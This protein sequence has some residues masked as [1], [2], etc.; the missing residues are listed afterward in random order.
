MAPP[1]VLGTKNTTYPVSTHKNK[2]KGKPINC[3]F[4]KPDNVNKMLGTYPEFASNPLPAEIQKSPFY[5]HLLCPSSTRHFRGFPV[6]RDT[7]L[8]ET[9]K[10]LPRVLR[11]Q[12]VCILYPASGSH[13][14]PLDLINHIFEQEDNK[15]NSA[16]II[17]TEIKEAALKELR[18]LLNKL[19]K[20]GV[21]AGLKETQ[22]NYPNGGS[23]TTFAFSY[24]G[25]EITL[26]FALNMSGDDYYKEE[27]LSESDV[28]VIHDPGVGD[29]KSSFKLLKSF[30]VSA[31]NNKIVNPPVI[32]MEN[33]NDYSAPSIMLS[34]IFNPPSKKEDETMY[35]N[36]DLLPGQKIKIPFPYGHRVNYGELPETGAAFYQSAIVYT[37]D[38][39]LFKQSPSDIKALL[40]KAH[41][42]ISE[43]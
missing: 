2:K 28:W 6:F 40:D 25:K 20:E 38:I 24:N 15:I 4:R 33:I 26:V 39:N 8:Y 36:E 31:G 29:S 41:S 1:I 30:L 21:Y 34:L 3:V 23:E 10:N 18:N 22:A 5:K 12:R 32:V 27:Y 35:Y 43:P 42:S 37:P 11:D 17:L 19:A 7:R 14:A 16:K 9:V 13:L